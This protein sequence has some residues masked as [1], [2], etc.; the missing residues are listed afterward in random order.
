MVVV[1]VVVVVE[2]EGGGGGGSRWVGFEVAFWVVK[3][4]EKKKTAS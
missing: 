1:V 2:D 3:K 4:D